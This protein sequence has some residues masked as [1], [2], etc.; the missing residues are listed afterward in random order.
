MRGRS[1]GG[2]AEGVARA[3]RAMLYG[4]ATVSRTISS[5]LRNLVVIRFA[6]SPEVPDTSLRAMW[7]T[8]R[9]GC[10]SRFSMTPIPPVFARMMNAI[11]DDSSFTDA[12]ARGYGADLQALWGAL[13]RLQWQRLGDKQRTCSQLLGMT[14]TGALATRKRDI[15]VRSRIGVTGD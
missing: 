4:A 8:G 3:K 2:G 15:L 10:S 5:S 11:L 7:P 1:G 12:V 9:R 13:R 6:Q 14:E